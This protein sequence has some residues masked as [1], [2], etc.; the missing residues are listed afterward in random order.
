M[1][2]PR[3]ICGGESNAA[4]HL[5]EVAGAGSLAPDAIP[6]ND[7]VANVGTP[8][9]VDP[10]TKTNPRVLPFNIKPTGTL[11]APDATEPPASAPKPAVPK[12]PVLNNVVTS[13]AGALKSPETADSTGKK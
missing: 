6:T 12:L 2:S 5:R 3:S 7:G 1:W 8:T 11:S 13:I 9:T 10:L 4:D